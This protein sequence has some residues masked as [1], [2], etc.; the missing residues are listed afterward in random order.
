MGHWDLLT[1]KYKGGRPAAIGGSMLS[2]PADN[3][4]IS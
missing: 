3:K 1:S 4:S 2:D